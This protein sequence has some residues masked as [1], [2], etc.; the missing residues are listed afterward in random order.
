MPKAPRKK[1][2]SGKNRS[3]R[4]EIPSCPSRSVPSSRHADY[5]VSAL[6]RR[7]EDKEVQGIPT[8]PSSAPAWYIGDED[9]QEIAAPSPPHPQYVGDDGVQEMPTPPN[10][11]S[12][13]S[14]DRHVEDQ[15]EHA[16]NTGWHWV[17]RS[18][19]DDPAQHTVLI[20]LHAL[21][22]KPQTWNLHQDEKN[23]VANAAS[24]SA[25]DFMID[26]MQALQDRIDALEDHLGVLPDLKDLP[27]VSKQLITE[28]QYVRN[29]V[30]LLPEPSGDMDLLLH[31]RKMA[32]LIPFA[33]GKIDKIDRDLTKSLTEP[34]AGQ[35]RMPGMGSS[36]SQDS[37]Y[38][39]RTQIGRT[40]PSRK[41]AKVVRTSSAFPIS[42]MF[43]KSMTR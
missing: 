43:H 9:V 18:D 20:L 28:I 21:A 14:L 4:L 12:H 38:L 19:D 7:I 10:S 15:I 17:Q 6:D 26:S 32:D 23:Q 8:P 24:A 11:Q 16:L 27:V 5:G 41:I 2:R 39:V 22:A 34:K 42:H 40:T 29:K 1:R 3:G 25:T 30:D 31:I 37:G 36:S 35:L 13:R 33:K